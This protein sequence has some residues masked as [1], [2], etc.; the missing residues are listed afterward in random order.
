MI[1]VE[2]QKNIIGE[3]APRHN[4]FSVKLLFCTSLISAVFASTKDEISQQNFIESYS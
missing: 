3:K 2:I 1:H 4:C